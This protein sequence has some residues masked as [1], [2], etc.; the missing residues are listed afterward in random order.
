MDRADAD[1]EDAT[2]PDGDGG[3][4]DKD[5]R[6]PPEQEPMSS[7]FSL[8]SVRD[9]DIRGDLFQIG[10][11]TGNL[12]P[13]PST[14]PPAELT[15]AVPR[16]PSLLLGRDRELES[17][18]TTS[19]PV[20][21]V[22][23]MGGAGKT[24]LALEAAYR[25]REQ[26]GYAGGVLFLDCRGYPRSDP[27]DREVPMAFEQVT[28]TLL[29]WLGVH[30]APRADAATKRLQQR[31]EEFAERGLPL[32]LM[33]DNLGTTFD[34]EP[35]LP[36]PR[37][38]RTLITTR[39]A[40]AVRD[41]ALVR[42]PELSSA[43]AVELLR[44][45]L[46]RAAPDDP[47]ARDSE[48]LHEVAEVC[49]R[50]PLTLSVIAA[51][52]SRSPKELSA[53]AAQLAASQRLT[54]LDSVRSAFE[55]S[56]RTLRES[57]AE[58]DREAAALFQRMGCLPGSEFTERSA[59]ALLDEPDAARAWALL[60]RLCTAHLLAPS[61]HAD[62]VRFL[63][64]AGEYASKLF[65]EL[66]SGADAQD[67]S[68]PSQLDVLVRLAE[69]AASATRADMSTV[70]YPEDPQAAAQ[71][72]Q[73]LIAEQ[74]AL[75]ML[76]ARAADMAEPEP[77]SEARGRL[78][79]ASR[80]I[81]ISL[82]VLYERTGRGRESLAA[83]RLLLRVTRAL[84]D[85]R[86]E[87]DAFLA[88]CR[89]LLAVDARPEA[90][91]CLHEA[92]KLTRQLDGYPT[93]FMRTFAELA[94]EVGELAA[95]AEEFTGLLDRY[96]KS[97]DVEGRL[98]ALHGLGRVAF[99]RDDL[100]EA[101]RRHEQARDLAQRHACAP[102]AER[103]LG[104]LGECHAR[105]GDTER[106]ARCHEDAKR[107]AEQRGFPHGAA[108][109]AHHLGDLH[110]DQGEDAEALERYAEAERGYREAGDVARADRL[111]ELI[112]AMRTGPER[113][114][115]AAD[116]PLPVE[117]PP[118]ASPPRR[119]P[120]TVARSM[121]DV[122]VV[123]G[124]LTAAQVWSAREGTP[125]V[126]WTWWTLAVLLLATAGA[127]RYAYRFTTIGLSH[128]WWALDVLAYGAVLG[129]FAGI[130]LDAGQVNAVVGIAVVL[131]SAGAT[132]YVRGRL[133]PR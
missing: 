76:T 127:R 41:A 133:R 103:A 71:A 40:D 27:R 2:E 7:L 37:A 89:G 72:L 51:M 94:C 33:L 115:L 82:V 69:S 30:D 59:A 117:P 8:N 130:A 93:E 122:L 62:Q 15:A 104:E 47:R 107:S 84:D 4:P 16:R 6:E 29:H 108:V 25:L 1:G 38:H 49:G 63:D 88:M 36:A 128:W 24:T 112:R 124:V 100:P 73:R 57:P 21:A 80:T 92:S 111:V 9:S 81:A 31:Y 66:P 70:D 118:I 19:N 11:W 75:G 91:R 65:A 114:T 18:L 83:S 54:V 126:P 110:R 28:S 79:T 22:V 50:L 116:P 14:E 87:L 67:G 3:K 132:T 99:L 23:G 78:L 20:C 120:S 106:A 74:D 97:G 39:A 61:G 102:H 77:E 43:A 17:V 119:N 131:L 95:G 96:R 5:G 52:L 48:G 105:L 26:G 123:L 35:L 13:L 101:V 55:L 44:A 32:L 60:D 90:A 58:I 125:A 129:Y 98:A 53:V 46:E 42:L 64:L 85:R 121:F 45:E 34:P 109:A 56:I 68:T 86:G 12:H 113:P 10:Q